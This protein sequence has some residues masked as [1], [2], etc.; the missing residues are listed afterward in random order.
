MNRR[1]AIRKKCL[2]CS[3]YKCWDVANCTCTDC[4]LY[5]FRS[6]KGKQDPK[7]R[8]IALRKYCMWCVVDQPVELKYC[9]K[10]CPLNDFRGFIREKKPNSHKNVSPAG[11][12][13]YDL[14]P[15]IPDITQENIPVLKAHI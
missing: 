11:L 13:R 9:S 3:N 7:E 15:A 8:N 2:E 14:L 12:P 4:A 5:P 1:Q 10:S 6:G